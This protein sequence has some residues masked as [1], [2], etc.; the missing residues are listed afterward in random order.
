MNSIS[1]TG[2]DAMRN[3]SKIDQSGTDP[4]RYASVSNT[5]EAQPYTT[6]QKKP[7]SKSPIPGVK[8]NVSVFERFLT[9]AAG[10]YLVYSG[11]SGKHKSTAKMAAGGALLARAVSGYC[12]IY[13]AAGKHLK[14]EGSNVNIRTSLV[15][16]RPAE[17][18]YNFWRRLENLPRFMKHLKSVTE[19]D[20]ITSEWTAQGP[21]GIGSVSWKAQI[22][23]DE[24]GKVLSWHSMPGS[25][26]E[27]A[28][29]V[30]FRDLG[31]N[32]TEIEVVI[33]YHAPLGVA[34]E[35]A[36]KL[37]NPVFEKAVKSDIDGLK[38]FLEEGHGLT[39]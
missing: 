23:M 30:N 35:A 17:Q 9:A 22:L 10:T 7:R 33:S 38:T 5:E 36:A 19:I 14:L 4:N 28:G 37:L 34:G 32:R 3:F 25:T 11:L 2:T 27:N 31:D 20:N 29:K 15:I 16:D 1:G 24:K 39:E 6:E 18:V 12:P 13:D 26:I 21:A 8:G